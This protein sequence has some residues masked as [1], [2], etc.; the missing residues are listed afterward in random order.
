MFLQRV[1]TSLKL[2]F[3][4]LR[5][6][7]QMIYGAWRVSSLPRPI[8]TIFG[9]SRFVQT[10]PYAHKANELAR[11]FIDRDISVLTGGGP[12]IMEAASCG[13]L[14][15][16]TGRGKGVS[17]GIGVKNLERKNPCVQQYFE[18]NYFY[19]RKWLLTR[20]SKAF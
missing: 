8:I 10:D 6:N 5:V 20:Y 14:K 7:F 11:L 19:A 15:G 13:A 4:L 9:G 3:Q 12:G 1:W 2:F 16:G 18:L 17:M